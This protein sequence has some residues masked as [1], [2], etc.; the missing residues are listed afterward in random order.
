[1]QIILNNAQV[2][3]SEMP[4]Q[5]G[6]KILEFVDQQGNRLTIPLDQNAARSIGAQLQ[7]AIVIAGG[8]LP[9]LRPTGS[10]N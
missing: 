8:P 5:P 9:P 4:G 6:G 7:T 2:F 1:M 10:T 3:I